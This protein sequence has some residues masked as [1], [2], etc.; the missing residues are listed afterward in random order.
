VVKNVDIGFVVGGRKIILNSIDLGSSDGYETS[1]GTWFYAICVAEPS[2]VDL[3][4]V[5]YSKDFLEIERVVSEIF[6]A[7]YGDSKGSFFLDPNSPLL[8]SVD[9]KS[10][11]LFNEFLDPS[12]IQIPQSLSLGDISESPEDGSLIVNYTLWGLD[13]E[14]LESIGEWTDLWKFLENRLLE[15]LRVKVSIDSESY[16]LFSISPGKFCLALKPSHPIR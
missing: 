15:Y 5:P 9:G 3:S 16:S 10:I 7:E 6:H 11:F 4:L 1:P 13:G 8:T 12:S 14:C 2:F